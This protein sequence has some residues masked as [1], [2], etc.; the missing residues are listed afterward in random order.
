MSADLSPDSLLSLSQVAR[1]LPPGRAGQLVHPATVLRW[2]GR[3]IRRTGGSR[4]KLAGTRIGGRWF[5]SRQSL[6]DF[7]TSLSSTEADAPSLRT[8]AQ[9]RRASE[10]AAEQLGAVG[11]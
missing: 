5:V 8:P 7:I 11:I 2:I 3:G 4:L 10:R 1:S 9:R 6:S